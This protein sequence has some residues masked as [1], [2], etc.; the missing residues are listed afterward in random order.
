MS[1]KHAASGENLFVRAFK[2]P[3]P[4]SL[5]FALIP[6]IAAIICLII[7]ITD[8]VYLSVYLTACSI[9]VLCCIGANLL[10]AYNAFPCKNDGS[11]S[12]I[13]S[14][15]LLSG[16]ISA[17]ASLLFAF[18]FAAICGASV[19]EGIAHAMLYALKNSFTTVFISFVSALFAVQAVY[20]SLFLA[21]LCGKKKKK[22]VVSRT[23]R[24][25]VPIFTLLTVYYS[26]ML[27]LFTYSD[28]SYAANLASEHFLNENA[29]W[30][31]TVLIPISIIASAVLWVLCIGRA[32]KTV[33][34]K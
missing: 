12:K 21:I 33:L 27:M 31:V 19:S 20:S 34:E 16:L 11:A 24:A 25:A 29:V 32:K 3:L 4:R 17:F 1:N 7:G 9:S 14:A 22:S 18:G 10:F 30:L 13:C 23:C 5:P 28:M 2:Y 6:A 8:T 26:L 15:L